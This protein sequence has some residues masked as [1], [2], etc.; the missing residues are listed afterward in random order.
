M[1]ISGKEFIDEKRQ[2]IVSLLLESMEKD[3]AVWKRGWVQTG[4]S[5]PRNGLNQTRYRGL[6]ALIL[7]LTAKKKG[8]N[9]NRWATFNQGADKKLYVKK[10]EKGTPIFFWQMRDRATKKEFDK[11]VLDG[12]EEDAKKEY[13]KENVY[14]VMKYYIVY[15]AEQFNE[16][17]K[18]ENLKS[19]NMSEDEKLKQNKLIESIIS[20]SEAPI[21]YDGGDKAFYRPS[22]DSIH[23]PKIE[24]FNTKNNYYA[25]ALHE[26]SHSTGHASRL[27]RD[28]TGFFGSEKYAME[29][30]RAELGAAFMSAD[31]GIDLTGAEIANHAAYLKSW[32]E[33]I[34]NDPDAFFKAA[35]DADKICKYICTNYLVKEEE[36]QTA[37]KTQELNGKTKILSL[38]E[39]MT[40]PNTAR[41][42][43]DNVME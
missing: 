5:V 15:N 21:H 26:I 29:E 28:L 33:V 6:N 19:E 16:F 20:N 30:L 24:Q 41:N 1:A 31:V 23:L 36:N 2:E 35:T 32:K 37:S 17:P 39:F 43:S 10:G 7:G 14:A 4:L 12:M 25:T 40:L 3:S 11:S 13:M 42:V 8:Y 38:K 27:N 18:L 9:D 34:K 22:T